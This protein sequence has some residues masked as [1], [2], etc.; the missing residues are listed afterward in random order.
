MDVFAGDS[1]FT[2]A[3]VNYVLMCLQTKLGQK[4]HGELIETVR[5]F[6]YVYRSPNQG[7]SR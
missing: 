3:E 7:P 6:G 4:E 5:G 2:P 1:R